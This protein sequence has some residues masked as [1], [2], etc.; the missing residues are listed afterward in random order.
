[1]QLLIF[2]FKLI[3]INLPT[4]DFNTQIPENILELRIKKIENLKL[5]DGWGPNDCS[6]YVTYNFPF[7]HD[8]HQTGRTATA[9]GTNSPG[10]I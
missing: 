6:L 1:M 4:F 10:K 3:D 9:K 8:A 2:R 7:P 5:P